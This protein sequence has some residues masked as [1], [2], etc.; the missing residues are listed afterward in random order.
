MKSYTKINE[1]KLAEFDTGH[2]DNADNAEFWSDY[3]GKNTV[4]S[5][6]KKSGKGYL[7]GTKYLL[8]PL[9]KNDR[10]LEAG[11]GRG[12]NVAA[13]DYRGFD[14]VGLDFSKHVIEEIKDFRPD[15]DVV[16]GDLRE[17]PFEKNEFSVYL[18]FGVIEHFDNPR[19]V[20]II[21]NEAKRVT[22]RLVYVSVPYYSPVLKKKVETLSTADSDSSKFYQYYFDKNEIEALLLKNGLKVH[23]ISYHATL[24]GLKRYNKV[25]KSL[26]KFYL[27]RAVI[28]RLRNTLDAFYGKKYGHMIGLWAYKV[29][30]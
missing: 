26:Y 19:D 24:V 3:W 18:S 22:S 30:D 14:I 23:R 27:F 25:V 4:I 7:G 6:L 28:V 1:G 11:C 20:E 2:D 5:A 15:L 16:V 17:L 12:Q 10:I 8:K 21:L 13:L 29:E 9:Q